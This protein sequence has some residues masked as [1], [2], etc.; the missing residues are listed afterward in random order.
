[1]CFKV[2]AYSLPTGTMCMKYAW[3]RLGQ[4][5]ERKIS[6]VQLM[7]DG[8]MDRQ[9]VH[10]RMPAEHAGLHFT[11]KITIK[12]QDLVNERC[13]QFFDFQVIYSLNDAS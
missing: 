10:Y 9:T 7:L 8:H 2:T 11:K 1:M 6:P 3:A 13:P 5:K 12:G 4:I